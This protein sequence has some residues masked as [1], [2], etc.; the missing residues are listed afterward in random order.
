M[1]RNPYGYLPDTKNVNMI[2]TLVVSNDCN[3]FVQKINK[4][5]KRD[6]KPWDTLSWKGQLERTRSWKV[7]SW[8]V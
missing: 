4:T 2:S 1:I 6:P 7:L 3:F 8:K 5:I